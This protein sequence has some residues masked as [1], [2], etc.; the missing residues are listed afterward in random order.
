LFDW[1]ELSIP[2]TADKVRMAA[3]DEVVREAAKTVS[4]EGPKW[5]LEI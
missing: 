2:L 5:A 4:E 1:F 3:A